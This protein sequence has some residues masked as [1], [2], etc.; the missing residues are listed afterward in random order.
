[1]TKYTV[2]KS[3]L[4][5]SLTDANF[6]ATGGEG[7][8]YIIGDDVYKVC[9]PGKM[10]PEAKIKE[11]SVLDH[12]KIIKP[13]DILL[14]SKNHTVGY[15]M[16]A[17]PRNP[18]PLAQMLSKT[19]REREGVRPEDMVQL[20]KQIADGLRSIH[21]HKG[22]LQVDGNEFNYM[23]T[24]D[25]KDVYFIDV[26]SYET[27]NYPADAIM[28]SIR[29]WNCPHDASGRYQW[30]ELTDWWSF[31]IIS[32]FMFTGIHPFKGRHPSFT[33]AKTFMMEQMKAGISVLDP[34]C[35]FP[36]AAVYQPFEQYIPGGKDGPYMQWY[37]ALFVQKK[38]L[39]A[40]ADFQ[41][42]LTIVTQVKE[43]VG[44]NN[45]NISLIQDYMSQIVGYLERDGKE[46]VVT[47]KNI[48][49]F[50]QAQSHPAKKFRVGFT[51][52]TNTAVAMWLED[53]N[54]RIRNLESKADLPI[55]L[56]AS[57][58]MSVDGRFYV[59]NGKYIYEIGFEE[60]KGIIVPVPNVIATVLPQ[61]TKLF[62][63]VVFQDTFDTRIACMFPEAG[64]QRIVKMPELE[65]YKIIDAKC[66]RNILMVVGMNA[67]GEYTRFVFRFSKD[68]TSYDKRKV[69]NITPTGLNFTVLDKGIVVMIT[70]EEKVEIFPSQKDSPQVK[71]ISDPAIEANMALCHA[72]DEVRF[73]MGSKLHRISVK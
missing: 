28:P 21:R 32:F 27:P 11:L 62:L 73:V 49:V 61:A 58:I 6:K 22:Y 8:I 53:N 41:A 19:Y 42:A 18:I 13:E 39:P 25:Y 37:K 31:A 23:V 52:K 50:N 30:S 45:F 20:V 67:D 15:T 10:I 63:G 70:E 46:I 5:V 3:G 4:V 1:M 44:S 48:F 69:E 60:R 9:L 68:F 51:S 40:P 66:K 17:V 24:D 2:R 26:N 38:R 59:H 7:S 34:E 14:D 29:D 55:N 72:G 12:P 54:V 16:K 57:D 71:S 35:K 33:N 47:K 65:G 36:L 64:H 56:T 43:I